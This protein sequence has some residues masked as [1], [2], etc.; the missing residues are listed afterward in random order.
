METRM[1]QIG[2]YG[3]Q[4]LGCWASNY[5]R[6]GARPLE[7]LQGGHRCIEGA[8]CMYVQYDNAIIYTSEEQTKSMR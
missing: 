3:L 4:I 8:R 1:R 5:L 7:Y 6:S 2:S